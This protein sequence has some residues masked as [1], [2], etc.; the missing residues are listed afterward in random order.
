MISI[1]GH[2]AVTWSVDR[3]AGV[4]ALILA[5]GAVCVGILARAGAARSLLGPPEEARSAH[6]WLVLATMVAVAVH[7]VA[8]MTDDVLDGG[9]VH[10]LVPFSGSYRPVAIAVGQVGAYGLAALWLASYAQRTMG[11]AGWR[12]AHR[13]V[14]VFWALAVI[15]S[16]VAA[17]DAGEGWFLVVTVVPVLAAVAVAVRYRERRPAKEPPAPPP[18]AVEPGP[19][20]VSDPRRIPDLLWSS[21]R[22]H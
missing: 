19:V 15:H 18:P 21:P 5:S 17:A 8:F 9:I 12:Y 20:A 6:D 3:A 14:V 16:Y 4:V 13:G 22:R 7:I 2:V 10:A 11:P 1:L